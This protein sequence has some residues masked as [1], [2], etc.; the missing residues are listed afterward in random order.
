[1][2]D[3]NTM[4]IHFF[5]PPKKKGTHIKQQS[6]IVS[7]DSL[8]KDLRARTGRGLKPIGQ[9]APA[10]DAQTRPQDRSAKSRMETHQANESVRSNLLTTFLIAEVSK[11]RD[12]RSQA[13]FWSPRPHRIVSQV[14]WLEYLCTNATLIG[15]V[16]A[17]RKLVE[18]SH[19]VQNIT[20]LK[21]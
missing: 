1:M 11:I 21:T 5:Y 10:A 3:A 14:K 9:N 18:S 2:S 20:V 17:L 6:C 15:E 19:M 16:N 4:Q 13:A 12:G 8:T 7:R